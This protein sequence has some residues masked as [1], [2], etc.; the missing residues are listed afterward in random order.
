MKGSEFLVGDNLE[1][2]CPCI[3]QVELA[4]RDFKSDVV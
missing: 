4:Q 1:E 3:G 2:S